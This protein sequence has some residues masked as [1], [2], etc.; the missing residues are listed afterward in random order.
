LVILVGSA[1]LAMTVSR[2]AAFVSPQRVTAAATTTTIISTKASFDFSAPTEWDLFYKNNNYTEWH[3]SISLERIASYIPETIAADCLMVGCG[4]SRLPQTALSARPRSRLVLMDTSETCLEQLH[5]IYGSAVGYKCGDALQMSTLF[6]DDHALFDIIIDKG[7]IDALLCGDGWD[8]DL[9]R[10][11][12]EAS[13]VLKPSSGK[14]LLISYR[15]PSST[16][17][18]LQEVGEAVGL[19]WEFDLREDSNDRV[20]VSIARKV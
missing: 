10:L 11:L 18:F 9:S 6:R 14:Y 7:L 8:G 19:K 1:F 3:S 15:L 2:A 13:K 5:Q 20:G 17:D 12:H 16:Q 4:N